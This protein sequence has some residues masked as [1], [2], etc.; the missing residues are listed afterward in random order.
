[1]EKGG[2]GGGEVVGGYYAIESF[3]IIVKVSYPRLEIFLSY[4]R[5]TALNSKIILMHYY[6]KIV[7][8]LWKFQVKDT[9]GTEMNCPSF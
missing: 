9:F 4:K 5:S 1:M 2:G 8:P 3:I 7:I 6:N